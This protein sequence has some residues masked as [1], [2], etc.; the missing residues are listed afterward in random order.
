M[1][2]KR[3]SPGRA[4]SSTTDEPTPETNTSDG[5]GLHGLP[6]EPHSTGE[7][8]PA[9]SEES[10]AGP[11]GSSGGAN[12]WPGAVEQE[13]SA[14]ATGT[15]PETAPDAH[16]IPAELVGPDSTGGSGVGT[17]TPERP[18][19]VTRTGTIWASLIFG[20]VALVV[21]LIF[22]LQ[23]GTSVTIHFITVSGNLPLGVALL[24]GAILGALVVLLLGAARVLQLRRL[25]RRRSRSLARQ[26]D[27]GHRRSRA[28]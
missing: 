3:R 21:V 17:T 1:N 8:S 2:W 25:A 26:V 6:S 16:P 13:G 11:S 12:A 28:A 23:N 10:G 19:P 5:P 22:I 15:A 7:S 20:I 14:P 18:I 4:A 27:H 9:E 24:F